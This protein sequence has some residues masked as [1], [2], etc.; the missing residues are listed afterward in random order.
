MRKGRRKFTN[1]L[2]GQNLIFTYDDKVNQIS[3]TYIISSAK[4]TDYV[5][6]FYE[7]FGSF[8]NKIGSVLYPSGPIIMNIYQN[9]QEYPGGLLDNYLN[10]LIV[11]NR[12][13]RLDIAATITLSNSFSPKY[14]L[15]SLYTNSFRYN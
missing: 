12:A 15:L 4:E 8:S 2:K 3:R 9:K 6:Y 10:Y 13:Y 11:R 5:K 14:R 1:S 7:G